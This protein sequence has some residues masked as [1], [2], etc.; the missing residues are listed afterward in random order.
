[1]YGQFDNE[2]SEDCTAPCPS[3]IEA[4]CTAGTSSPKAPIIGFYLVNVTTKEQKRCPAGKFKPTLDFEKCGSCPTGKYQNEHGKT[5]CD[6]V[7][8]GSSVADGKPLLDADGK[9]LLD[10]H[11]NAVFE[12]VQLRCPRSG[13][14]CSGIHKFYTGGVW[15]DSVIR[16]QLPNE[17]YRS[18]ANSRR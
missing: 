11:G 18:V 13:V 1:M 8:P 7:E 16:D 3:Y 9:P 17:L 15:H 12:Q 6:V 10:A 14:D 5:Y 2:I 4:A